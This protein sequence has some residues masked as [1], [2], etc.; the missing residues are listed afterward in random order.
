MHLVTIAGRPYAV[1][2]GKD[3]AVY[4]WYESSR[5]G[6]IFLQV[7]GRTALAKEDLPSSD[8][9]VVA[10]RDGAHRVATAWRHPWFDYKVDAARKLAFVGATS[11]GSLFL[12]LHYL[13]RRFGSAVDAAGLAARAQALCE[14]WTVPGRLLEPVRDQ[15]LSQSALVLLD[16]SSYFDREDA[17]RVLAS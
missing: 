13:A 12:A 8:W 9:V 17:T 5:S 14:S 3:Y 1:I 16:V 15:G 4:R 7:A 11:A 2:N 6:P 10:A